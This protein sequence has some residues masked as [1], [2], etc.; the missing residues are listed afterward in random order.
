[1]SQPDCWER[2]ETQASGGL[3][4]LPE[5]GERVLVMGCGTSYYVAAAYAWLREQAGHGL[6]D[7][8]I[9]SEMPTVLRNYDRVMAIS[10]SGTTTEVVTALASLPDDMAITAVL[11]ELDS[12]IA[13]IAADVIDLSYADERSVVQTRFPTTL[14]TLLR[15]N[16][17]ASAPAI[18]EFIAAARTA[19]TQP[20]S[21]EVPGQFVVLGTGWAA[22]LA[23]EGALKCRESA[24]LWAEAYASGEYRHGPISVAGSRTLV[25]A[26]TPLSKSQ[27]S[28]ITATG[29]RVHQA[30]EDPQVELVSI[31]R[32]AVEWARRAGRDADRPVH[33]SRSVVQP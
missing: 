30:T 31:Q 4:G 7:A 10:R 16:L 2:A 25:W 32:H 28:A 11:G 14:L 19:T 24:G 5:S 13:E 21:E 26:M 9:A 22:P 8:V 23:Q 18:S 15:S 3:A 6:T 20:L 1:M 27:I 29:A 12:P 17:G 33:L